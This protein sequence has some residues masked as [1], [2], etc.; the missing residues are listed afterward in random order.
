VQSL[1]QQVVR[2]RC[3]R[4]DLEAGANNRFRL[5]EMSLLGVKRCKGC[6][7]AQ[8]TRVFGDAGGELHGGAGDIAALVQR[9]RFPE[10]AIRIVGGGWS[11][12]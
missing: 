4:R 6:V 11:D 12:G 1:G 10:A 8:I 5:A 3:R 7:R 9:H 2:G